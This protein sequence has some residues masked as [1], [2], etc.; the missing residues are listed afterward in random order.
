MNSMTWSQREGCQ[1]VEGRKGI[2]GETL[3]EV[4]HRFTAAT[5]VPLVNIKINSCL[6]IGSIPRF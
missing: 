5:G 3:E 6:Q 1:G 4:A 2:S